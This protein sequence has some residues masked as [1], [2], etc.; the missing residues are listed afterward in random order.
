MPWSR[1]KYY[2]NSCIYVYIDKCNYNNTTQTLQAFS[3]NLTKLI[4]VINEDRSFSVRENDGYLWLRF[5]REIRGTT[6]HQTIL[7]I[8]YCIVNLLGL[9][10]KY[11]QYNLN[12]FRICEFIPLAITVVL[13]LNDT[14]II[15]Y[16]NSFG[17]VININKTWT[18]YKTNGSKDEHDIVFTRKP[19]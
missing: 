3:V 5:S 11:H 12:L 14:N 15:W 6:I 13:L 16:G 4:W 2:K 18:L 17:Y 10:T 1:V 7:S 19:K 8:W 9:L